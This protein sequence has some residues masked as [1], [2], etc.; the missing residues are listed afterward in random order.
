MAKGKSLGRKEEKKKKWKKKRKK[1]EKAWNF[2]I[3]RT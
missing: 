1:I 2:R 3:K